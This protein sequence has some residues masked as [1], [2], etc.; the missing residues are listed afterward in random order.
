MNL[1]LRDW[2]AAPYN[3][4]T[5]SED[6]LGKLHSSLE[7]YGDLGCIV[8]N[9]QTGNIVCGHQRIKGINRNQ[10][11]E[12][13]SSEP[14]KNGDLWG[15][16]HKDENTFMV[17]IVDWPLDKEK[18]ANVIANAEWIQ[19][20]FDIDMLGDILREPEISIDDV[21]IDA[22]QVESTFAPDIAADILGRESILEQESEQSKQLREDLD[23]IR[24]ETSGTK[25][26][27][28][29]KEKDD[30]AFYRIVVF[31]GS[32]EAEDFCKRL[33]YN[34]DSRYIDGRHL[35]RMLQLKESE[36]CNSK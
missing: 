16:L 24:E 23:E 13:I 14:D 3:P 20:D 25:T 21:F 36:R 12:I 6:T 15:V 18:R 34:K 28:E 35:S 11:I 4:R 5:I 1:R 19:G 31:K 33:G 17:R 10:N 27:R 29:T 8:L 7:Q 22:M 2:K 9:Q 30:I 26:R 32:E